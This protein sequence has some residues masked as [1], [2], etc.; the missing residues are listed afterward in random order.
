MKTKILIADDNEN[1]RT[2]IKTKMEQDGYVVELAENGLEAVNKAEESV[3]DLI[4]LD[5]MMPVMDGF[6]ALKRLKEKDKTRYIPV[7]MLTA[8]S[9]TTDKVRSLESGAE[10]YVVKP[11]S[12][13]EISAR[14]KSL[15]S[16]RALQRELRESEK[17]AALGKLVDDISH[18]IRNPLVTIGGMARRLSES[19]TGDT[20]LRYLEGITQGVSRM[21]HMMERV[22]EYKRVLTSN[23]VLTEINDVISAAIEEAEKLIHDKDITISTEIEGKAELKIDPENLKVAIL[24]I[25]ENSIEAIDNR[26]IIRVQTLL[27][28]S[29]DKFI[30]N[31]YDNGTGMDE[32]MLKHIF[33]PFY[34]SKMTGAG[35]G[36][37]I[38]HR[39]IQDNNGEVTARSR[40]GE[41]T[42]LSVSFHLNELRAEGLGK[43]DKASGV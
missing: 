37:A 28:D 10:D 6:E 27:N 16:M 35:L 29:G 14:V 5:I 31:I 42:L 3:P 19:I 13:A 23:P 30:L 20:Q 4:I 18:E 38:T 8:R 40:K 1:N 22:D 39:I 26:G 7:I 9:G 43:A 32:E 11:Y 24:N 33:H 17:M 21:E 41:G 34:T 36:L 2:L 25:L 12:L 15:L